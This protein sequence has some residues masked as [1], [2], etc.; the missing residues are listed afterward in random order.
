MNDLTV[1]A[2]FTMIGIAIVLVLG[3]G[4]VESQPTNCPDLTSINKI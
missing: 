3:A 4:P 2:I 1:A